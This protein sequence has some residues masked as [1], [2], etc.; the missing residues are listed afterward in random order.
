VTPP[1]VRVMTWNIHGA[2]GRNP[3]FDLARVVEFIK[4]HAPD[5]VALQEVDSRRPGIGPEPFGFLQS[6]LGHFG[7]GAKTI[8]TK[9]GAYGQMLLSR[10]PVARHEIHDIS[11]PEREPRRIIEADIPTDAGTLR[12]I[13]THLGLSLKE[14]RSQADCLAA[15]IAARSGGTVVLG[16]F[17]DWFWV[18]S[19]RAVIARICPGRTRFRTFPA[20]W[21]L[22]RLDRV[23][24]RPASLLAKAWI[25]PDA[26]HISDHLP[27]IVDI[28]PSP[29][30]GAP[31][32]GAAV[33]GDA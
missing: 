20:R 1:P 4:A 5:I 17:N 19:V 13:A 18:G 26:R 28:Q 7:I 14:R 32:G 12:V 15:V 25:D 2:L 21:P 31:D 27:V 3:R 24:C 33:T 10:W 6:A 22:L 30:S 23:Y 8:V 9:D 11:H 29:G 16:D